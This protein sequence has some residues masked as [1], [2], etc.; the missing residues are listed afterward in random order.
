M[1]LMFRRTHLAVL[2]YAGLRLP[3]H[4]H[5]YV[6]RVAPRRIPMGGLKK[7]IYVRVRGP[8]PERLA[9]L[10]AIVK[11]AHGVRV[12]IARGISPGPWQRAQQE[13]PNV[14]VQSP[15]SPELKLQNVLDLLVQERVLNTA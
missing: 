1:V 13:I 6:G 5:I 4:A 12:N 3:A 8:S 2:V 9:C 7:L 15:R 10:G 11:L 14:G